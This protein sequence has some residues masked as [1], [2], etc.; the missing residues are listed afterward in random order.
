MWVEHDEDDVGAVDE[1]LADVVEGVDPAVLA[2]LHDARHVHHAHLWMGAGRGQNA[3]GGAQGHERLVTVGYRGTC[4][5]Y[6]ADGR[7]MTFSRCVLKP[8]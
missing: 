8:Q 3:G 7:L 4:C 5:R 1:P 2:T 6:W